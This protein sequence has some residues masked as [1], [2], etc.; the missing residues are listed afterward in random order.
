[1]KPVGSGRGHWLEK[2]CTQEEGQV[3]GKLSLRTKRPW[4][5]AV[6]LQFD[7]WLPSLGSIALRE[8]PERGSQ[9]STM[10]PQEEEQRDLM[11]DLT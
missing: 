10:L 11:G 2:R 8:P 6:I 5:A 3:I 9:G 1:M 7:K 4:T